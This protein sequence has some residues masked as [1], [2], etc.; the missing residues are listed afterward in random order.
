MCDGLE[1]K[2]ADEQ[3]HPLFLKQPNKRFLVPSIYISSNNMKNFT[4]FV[5]SL[6]IL[7]SGAHP[8]FSQNSKIYLKVPFLCQAP[9]G[10]W[11]QPWQDGCEE[12]AILMVVGSPEAQEILKMVQF[13]KK[14]YGGHFDLNAKQMAQL[15]KDYYDIEAQV[16]YDISVQDIKDEL[17][18]GNPVIVPAAGRMLPNQFY[19]PP[20]PIYHAL[21]IIGYNDETGEFV[22]N[23]PGT[24]RGQ[25]FR[26]LYED[27]Y[28][29]I[30]DWESG[31]KVFIVINRDS[32]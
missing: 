6:I 30:G 5:I 20:G 3:A 16:K 29:A 11:N 21:V 2:K 27:L 1:K 25:N 7:I 4:I 28:Y 17:D 23:D 26:Y 24:R 10:N 15:V 8:G 14:K 32:P 9:Y 31:Q 22:T 12:A 19:T 18:K 13:Q